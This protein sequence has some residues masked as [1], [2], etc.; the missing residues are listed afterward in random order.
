[1]LGGGK[2][3]CSSSSGH[4]SRRGRREG[5]GGERSHGWWTLHCGS[6][7][8][9]LVLAM[10]TVLLHGQVAS[11]CS[12]SDHRRCLRRSDGRLRGAWWGNSISI[13]NLVLQT[14]MRKMIWKIGMVRKIW[15][16]VSWW[17]IR[18]R[19]E[20]RGSIRARDWFAMPEFTGG[21]TVTVM[22][23]EVLLTIKKMW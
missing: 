7:L 1:M 22:I 9:V 15:V 6:M 16:M 23:Q 10:L 5:R 14:L 12:C 18:D 20:R 2:S 17:L 8:V 13:I 4:S 3:S 21:A 11:C 19:I